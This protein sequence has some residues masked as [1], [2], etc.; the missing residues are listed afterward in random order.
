MVFVFLILTCGSLSLTI[1]GSI[2][3]AANDITLFFF[4]AE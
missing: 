3:V 4:M 1:S 2:H